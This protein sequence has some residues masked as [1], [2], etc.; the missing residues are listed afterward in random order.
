MSTVNR[1]KKTQKIHKFVIDKTHQKAHRST[2]KNELTTTQDSYSLPLT[3]NAAYDSQLSAFVHS[4]RPETFDGYSEWIRESKTPETRNMRIKAVKAALIADAKRQGKDSTLVKLRIDDQ[5]K[6]AGIKSVKV[7]QSIKQDDCLSLDDVQTLVK[8]S[9]EKTA[10]IVRTLYNTAC[11]VS[12]LL[13]MKYSNCRTVK[14]QVE[15]TIVGKGNKERRVYIPA[16][17]LD[18]IRDTF[19]GETFLFD[20]GR[21]A[22]YTRQ[23]IHRI[24]QQA[25]QR[26]LKIQNLHPH[27]IRHSFATANLDRLGLHKTSKYLGHSDVSTTSRFYLHNEPEPDEIIEG[28]I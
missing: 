2:M 13:S 15:I 14:N 21:G 5:F 11:R 20:N 16:P 12:E 18:E 3:G 8:R 6:Q 22:P 23:Y 9:D 4:G 19:R 10:L 1:Y 27:T 25:G 7:N 17:L 28:A 26:F 24:V